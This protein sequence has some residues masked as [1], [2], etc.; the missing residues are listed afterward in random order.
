MMSR[1]LYQRLTIYTFSGEPPISPALPLLPCAMEGMQ[2]PTWPG[3]TGLYFHYTV[4]FPVEPSDFPARW[5]VFLRQADWLASTDPVHP[6]VMG[7][8]PPQQRINASVM[9]CVH[10]FISAYVYNMSHICWP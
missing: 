9:K 4:V 1:K 8:S 5:F 3:C 6:C 7:R 2:I 10:I